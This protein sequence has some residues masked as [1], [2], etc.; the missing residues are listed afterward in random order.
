MEE[1]NDSRKNPW[2]QPGLI[3]FGRLSGWIAGPVILAVI[4]GKWLDRKY[5][6]APWLFL[7][8]VLVAFGISIFGIVRDATCEMKRIK[9]DKK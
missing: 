7:L 9:K 3:L 1:N 8:S 6:T 4:L 5:G 2:W